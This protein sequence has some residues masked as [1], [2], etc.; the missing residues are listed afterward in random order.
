MDQFIQ[1]DLKFMN[2]VSTMTLIFDNDTYSFTGNGTL[3]GMEI[4]ATCSGTT[5]LRDDGTGSV[6]GRDLFVSQNGSANYSFKDISSI[7]DN[8]TQRLGAAF[9]DTNATGNLEFLKSTVEG[10][11]QSYVDE[12]NRKGIFAMWK[13][14]GLLD[15]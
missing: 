4:V 11:Y 10:V 14:K 5:N 1:K 6:I 2:K 13:L 15:N 8:T 12:E 3:D 9:F 7:I